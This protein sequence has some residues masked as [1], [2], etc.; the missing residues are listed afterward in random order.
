MRVLSDGREPAPRPDPGDEGAG[1]FSTIPFRFREH[2]GTMNKPESTFV[3]LLVLTCCPPAGL[4]ASEPA[5]EPPPAFF[6]APEDCRAL[7]EHT[8]APD[9]EYKA[10]V[11]VRGR[12]VPPADLPGGMQV[13]LP[14]A[15]PV[16]INVYIG[17]PAEQNPPPLGEPAPPYLYAPQA[18]IGEVAVVRTPTGYELYFNGEPLSD[19]LAADIRNACAEWEAKQ[20][21]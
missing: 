20:R 19:P 16:G 13:R 17:D 2:T 8:P 6:I 7:V 9:V 11:D 12:P 10:G 4:R 18:Q 15:F 3:A 5:S 21:R 1:G 14:D